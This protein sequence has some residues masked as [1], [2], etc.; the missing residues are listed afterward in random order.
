[1]SK[2]TF[3]SKFGQNK[4]KGPYFGLKLSNHPKTVY[5]YIEITVLCKKNSKNSLILQILTVLTRLKAN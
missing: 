1:M 3:F 5:P 4:P 2:W